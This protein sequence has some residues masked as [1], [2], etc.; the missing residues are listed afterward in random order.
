MEIPATAHRVAGKVV[1]RAYSRPDEALAGADRVLTGALPAVTDASCL[2]STWAATLH[3][4][5]WASLE[6]KAWVNV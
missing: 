1:P 2:S 6:S 5:W 4:R 3:R